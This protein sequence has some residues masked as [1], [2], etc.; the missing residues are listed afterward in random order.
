M[1]NNF[2][3]KIRILDGG[4]GQLLLEKGMVSMGTLW[5]AS[6]LLDEKYHQMLVDTH[7]SY[8]NAGSDVIVTNTFSCRKFRLIENNV[9]NQFKKLNEIACKL[10]IKAKDLS[11]KNVLVAGSIPSQRDTYITDNRDIK[12]IE[13]DMFEQADIL[14][15]FTDF[16]Y[17]DVI[18]STNEVKACLLY[19]SPSPRD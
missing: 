8:I 6:A 1:D 11:K 18:S 5:S 16:L 17:L 14:S 9:G 4:M 2:F 7:L 13:E 12:L 10:A 15:E 19:T 3:K